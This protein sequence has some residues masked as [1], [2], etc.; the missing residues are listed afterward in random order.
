L[1]TIVAAKPWPEQLF[2]EKQPGGPSGATD[3]RERDERAAGIDDSIL[4]R[5]CRAQV[6]SVRQAV[7]VSGSH[8]HTF[9]NPA[10]IV[11]E[12]CCYAQAAGTAVHG[13]PTGEFTWFNG[14]EWQYCI[15]VACL[16]HLGWFFSAPTNSFFGLI[17]PKLIIR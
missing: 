6:T 8:Q 2:R 15:C 13:E 3:T 16:E 17:L 12:I 1:T 7:S 10:G 9:F 4:C 14:Y 11:F 5:S